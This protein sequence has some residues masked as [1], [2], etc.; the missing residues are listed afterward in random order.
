MTA[1]RGAGAA[2][3]A[4][5]TMRAHAIIENA[6]NAIML[7]VRAPAARSARLMPAW[8][9]HLVHGIIAA[10]VIAL[11]MILVD[12]RRLPDRVRAAAMAGRRILRDHGFRPLR[13]DTGADRRASFSSSPCSLRRHSIA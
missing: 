2:M 11:A 3:S 8:R 10:V 6:R 7:L 13:L 9:R 1:S 12:Q 5:I 4:T